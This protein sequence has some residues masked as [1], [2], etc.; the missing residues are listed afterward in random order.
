MG[1]SFKPWRRKFGLLTLVL[2]CVFTAGWFR[3]HVYPVVKGVSRSDAE[4]SYLASRN[5]WLLWVHFERGVPPYT[6]FVEVAL[7][8][9]SLFTGRGAGP[10]AYRCLPYWSI[11]IPLTLLSA[12]LLLSK[13]RPSTRSE[14]PITNAN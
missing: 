12:Y 14:P 1:E 8:D 3:S 7:P 5:G 13:P 11:V 4:T 6:P 10:L 9:G 2:A